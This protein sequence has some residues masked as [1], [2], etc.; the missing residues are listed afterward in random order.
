MIRKIYAIAAVAVSVFLFSCGDTAD[1]SGTD[2]LSSTT[3]TLAVDAV[4]L[5]VADFDAKAP[6][7]VD[8]E[9]EVSGIVDHVCKHGGKKILLVADDA[10]MHI[11]S[12][13]RFDEALSGQEITVR[14]IVREE[15]VDEAYL[16]QWEQDEI[17]KHSEG[18]DNAEERIAHA[19][20]QIKFYRD[21]MA[22]TNVN[23]LSFYSLEYLSYEPKK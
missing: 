16:Q 14:G 18:E 21:S 22:T 1:K 10:K 15:R 12:E 13:T 19:R 8:K 4:T 6:E 2:S 3:D 23:H 17:N 5:G 11:D 20:E 9:V 7:F